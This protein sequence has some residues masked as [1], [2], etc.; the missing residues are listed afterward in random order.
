MKTYCCIILF[1]LSF[2]GFA[3]NN[4]IVQTEDGKIV[5]L[6]DDFTWEYVDPETS[7]L[8]ISI[9]GTSKSKESTDCRIESNFIEPKLDN[10]IQSQ[11]KKGRAT[12]SHIKE[13]VA[14]DNGCEVNDVTLLSV[15]ETKAKGMYHFCANG[16]KVVYKR[17]GHNIAKKLNLF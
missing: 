6:K 16:T 9:I 14:K 3:Q 15:S 12:I 17:S 2:I 13:K 5:L 1:L 4:H 11:L 10:K 8:D 7:E